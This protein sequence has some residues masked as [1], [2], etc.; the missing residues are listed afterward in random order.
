MNL[1]KDKAFIDSNVMIYS[2][3]DLFPD[4]QNKARQLINSYNDACISTQVLNEFVSAFNKKFKADWSDIMNSL[5]EIRDNF[6]IFTNTPDTVKEACNIAKKY[7]FSF[8]DSLIIAAALECGCNTLYSEDM[9]DGQV[10]EN[11]LKIINPFK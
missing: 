11:S 2:Y 3:S 4:K 1:M 5:E 6:T 8:Y 7:R 10:I 9:H